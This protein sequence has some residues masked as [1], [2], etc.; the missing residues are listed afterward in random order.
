MQNKGMMVVDADVELLRTCL[1]NSPLWT[2]SRTMS[3]MND[4]LVWRKFSSV[5]VF[6]ALG[7][8]S[9]TFMAL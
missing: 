2:T 6:K 3:D 9:W 5:Y 1:V 7:F 8:L 4:G